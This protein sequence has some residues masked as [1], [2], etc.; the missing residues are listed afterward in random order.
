MMKRHPAPAELVSSAFIAAYDPESC[1]SCGVCIDRC[2]MDAIR[3]EE[4]KVV[5]DQAR[6]IGC[7]LCVTTCPTQS[8]VLVRK[9]EPEQKDVPR[10]LIE[11]Y[12]RIHKARKKGGIAGIVKDLIISRKAKSSLSK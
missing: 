8:L 1:E 2:Q 9:P 12:V 7:G 10:N 6:C 5:F 4:D 11:T 3:W